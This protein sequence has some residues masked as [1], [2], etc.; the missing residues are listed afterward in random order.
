M[1]PAGRRAAGKFAVAAAIFLL[2]APGALP[3]HRPTP[4][5]RPAKAQRW[6]VRLSVRT[7]GFQPGK[8][9]SIPL[10]AATEALSATGMSQR[11]PFVY[12]LGRQVFNLERGVRFPY[13]L[14]LFSCKKLKLKREPRPRHLFL[15]VLILMAEI[16]PLEIAHVSS[17]IGQSGSR[18]TRARAAGLAN[19]AG[20]LCRRRA[21]GRA[22][23]R[24]GGHDG[25]AA[26]RRSPTPASPP[27]STGTGWPSLPGIAARS[28]SA[29]TCSAAA[30]AG[31][32][33]PGAL[34]ASRCWR[35]KS[36][37]PT[38]R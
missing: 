4:S 20:H 32:P 17:S 31:M 3:K 9:G 37:W 26:G 6:P 33:R 36:S 13:G 18:S 19:R 25:V 2:R 16:Y 14:P 30:S 15:P 34:P 35:L 12:R 38:P 5:A 1:R 29:A 7:P 28:R 27:R 24:G 23:C 10:R 22:L 21:G 11:G 8:R